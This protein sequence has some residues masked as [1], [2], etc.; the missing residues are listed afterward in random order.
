MAKITEF[1]NGW[2]S[3]RRVVPTDY[4]ADPGFYMLAGLENKLAGLLAPRQPQPAY[5][6]GEHWIVLGRDTPLLHN[7]ALRVVGPLPST[8]PLPPPSR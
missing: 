3:M 6:T 1:G 4:I 5:W 2:V 8:P 7:S